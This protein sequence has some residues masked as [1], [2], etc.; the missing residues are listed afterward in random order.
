MLRM[1]VL[2]L[3]MC[4]WATVVSAE[5]RIA[6]VIGNGDYETIAS[7]KNP[8]ADAELIASTLE[9]LDFEVTLASNSNLQELR[10]TIADFGREL[11]S[12]GR[13]ATGLFYYAGHGV[14]S[15]GTNYIL[16]VDTELTDAAD[17]DLVAL[18]A[19]SVLRQMFSAKNKTNI[20]I[21]DA[22]R[23][24][25]FESI[26]EF[27][28]TG[29]AEMKAPTGTYMAF[30][31]APGA[32]AMDGRSGGNSAFSAALAKALS[33]ENSP[34]E[35]VFKT[36]RVDV[37]AQTRG[38]QTP[39]STS[40]LTDEFIFAKSDEPAPSSDPELQAWEAVRQSRDALQITLF[41]RSN[42]NSAFFDEARS[43]LAEVIAE[44]LAPTDV[45]S[46]RTAAPI[47]SEE[48]LIEAAR[49]SGSLSDYEAY[50]QAYPNGTYAELAQY[51][52]SVLRE[53][54]AENGE[55]LPSPVPAATVATAPSETAPVTLT[56]PVA[57]GPEQLVGMTI[58]E[59]I[60]SR[61][62]FPPIEDLP[63]EFWAEKTCSDCH[64]WNPERLCTQ[65]QVYLGTNQ[66]RSLSKQHPF[67]GAFKKHLQLW[68]S[69]DCR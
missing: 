20:F 49:V 56:S 21:L 37:L 11:R 1:I 7:L 69:N 59:I 35:Q 10:K 63:E 45:A 36:V 17:L 46:T 5:K 65:A 13:D 29:L 23:D 54:A 53:K 15:F 58:P 51:E 9:Q 67:G 14:Q 61:P 30:A 44:E 50:L 4:S 32:V 62:L 66:E 31:T 38:A 12:A 25:P 55:T 64:Q 27:S 48:D 22:C 40:S 43:L 47:A 28:D 26:P 2:G 3:A 60:L 6:L 8:V 19:G 68:A 33:V 24:N 16:P 41:M 39:W 57:A 52:V 34:I 18:E 42:P